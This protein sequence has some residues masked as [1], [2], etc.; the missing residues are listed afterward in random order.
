[1]NHIRRIVLA[2]ERDMEVL[3][4]CCFPPNMSHVRTWARYPA[5]LVHS[6]GKKTNTRYTRNYACM[7][8]GSG[9]TFCFDRYDM[10]LLAALS[11]PFMTLQ[12]LGMRKPSLDEQIG[13]S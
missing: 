3:L 8:Y 12:G 13:G 9:S 4:M 2:C 7:A 10:R 11:C 6:Y 5:T 1:M